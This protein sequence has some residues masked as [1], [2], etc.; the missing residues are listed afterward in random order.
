MVAMVMSV[1]IVGV[2]VGMLHESSGSRANG[3][4]REL[5]ASP[6]AVIMANLK[7]NDERP[8][9]RTPQSSPDSWR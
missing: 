2:S 6:S 8:T 3:S 9:A 5:T 1:L 7:D 4:T